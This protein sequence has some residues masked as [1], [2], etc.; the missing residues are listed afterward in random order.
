MT[1]AKCPKC[2][3]GYMQ[4]VLIGGTTPAVEWC[5]ET[6]RQEDGYMVVSNTCYE[7]QLTAAEAR[8][9]ELEKSNGQFTDLWLRIDRI[10][11]D[12]KYSSRM[13]Q[14]DAIREAMHS[15]RVDSETSGMLD[16][17]LDENKALNERHAS[18]LAKLK[19]F[20]DY[21][22]EEPPVAHTEYADGWQDA[23]RAVH[24]SLANIIQESGQ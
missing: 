4:G 24:K 21:L 5:C 15:P 13:N 1:E 11:D 22:G 7:N 23:M 8:V 2:G 14:L 12:T 17:L 18:L 9:A 19:A 10:L 20:N 6:Y 16:Q 3:A